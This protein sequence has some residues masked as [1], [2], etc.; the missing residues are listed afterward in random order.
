MKW[1]M[2]EANQEYTCILCGE[3]IS[4]G[5]K[6]IRPP[7]NDT[8]KLVSQP[9]KTTWSQRRPYFHEDCFKNMR[10]KY[11]PFAPIEYWKDYEWVPYT[12]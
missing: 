11:N 1:R 7:L 12:L 9:H 4:I 10:E 5:Q 8:E 3:S 2:R 6:Y